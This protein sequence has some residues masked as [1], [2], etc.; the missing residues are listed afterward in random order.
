MRRNG[1]QRPWHPQ[2]VST[3][4]A[5]LGF[6]TLYYKSVSSKLPSNSVVSCNIAFAFCSLS[7]LFFAFLA[8][9]RNSIDIRG[10]MEQ[11]AR[12]QR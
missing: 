12:E 10:Q 8:T 9:I 3:W 5:F 6:I 7:L 1:L 11:E 4:L 2:Q